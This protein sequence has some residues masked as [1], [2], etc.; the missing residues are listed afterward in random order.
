MQQKRYWLRGA[1]S[2]LIGGLLFYGFLMGIDC[3]WVAPQHYSCFFDSQYLLRRVDR[4]FSLEGLTMMGIGALA[5]IIIGY[6]YGK[7]RA[8]WLPR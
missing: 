1:L 5:G 3:I 8:Y 2:G 4:I 6:T 7:T